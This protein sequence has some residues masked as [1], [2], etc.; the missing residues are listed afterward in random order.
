MSIITVPFSWLLLKLYDPVHNYGLAIIMFALIV[1]LILL[2]FQVKSKRSMMRTASLSPMLKELEKKHGGNKQ[3]YQAEVSKLYQ[4]EKIN[5]M[6]GCIWTLIPFPILIALYSVV[7]APLTNVMRLSAEQISLLAEKITSYGVA[8]KGGAYSELE[9]ARHIANHYD[10]LHTLVPQIIDLN[11]NFFG[12][13]LV[14]FSTAKLFQLCRLDQLRRL[15]PRTGVIS[16]PIYIRTFF[17]VDDESLCFQQRHDGRSRAGR[18]DEK[19]ESYNAFYVR[20]HLL[21]HACGNGYL[22]DC[23]QRLCR[24]TGACYEQVL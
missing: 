22:L 20:I 17:L 19:H 21:H 14:R 5:P 7:R 12:N 24:R 16:H 10:E 8:L 6:S 15:G 9:I 1:K 3:K 2:P 18:N 23:Q 13:Q 4:E 11:F